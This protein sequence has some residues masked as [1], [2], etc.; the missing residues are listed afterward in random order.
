MYIPKKKLQFHELTSPESRIVQATEIHNSSATVV[1]QLIS[2]H[3]TADVAV[4]IAENAITGGNLADLY[5]CALFAL[6]EQVDT[7]FSRHCSD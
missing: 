2:R 5:E 7:A 6:A 3:I 1:S 4:G